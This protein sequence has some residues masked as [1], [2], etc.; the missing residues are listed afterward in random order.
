M[1]EYVCLC[2]LMLMSEL[3]LKM[4][5][6]FARHKA[7]GYATMNKRFNS[8]AMNYFHS[9]GNSLNIHGGMP[10]TTAALPAFRPLI[11]W[12][13]SISVIGSSRT[14]QYIII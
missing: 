5:K 7:L 12:S 1:R 6:T 14:G 4:V 2:R 13:T 10:F 11:S 8:T 9:T 3:I